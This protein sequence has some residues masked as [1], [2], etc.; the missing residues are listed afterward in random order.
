MKTQQFSDH[1]SCVLMP[2]IQTTKLNCASR[3]C[4]TSEAIKIKCDSKLYVVL[5]KLV[6]WQVTKKKWN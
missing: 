6:W 3:R 4:A 1:L 5:D 2:T